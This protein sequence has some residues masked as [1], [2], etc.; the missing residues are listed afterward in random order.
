MELSVTTD[1]TF[2]TPNRRLAAYHLKQYQQQQLA[3]GKKS[4]E[5]MDILPISSW[6]ERLWSTWSYQEI[7]SKNNLLNANQELI[8]WEKIISEAK[9]SQH[10]LQ[11]SA[12]AEIAKSA[13][14]L[15]KQWE[16]D[17]H[18]P[19]LSL[20]EDSQTF[21]SWAQTFQNQCN[22]NHWVDHIRTGKI[23]AAK[24][25][26]LIGFT[27]L[28]PQQQ[29]LLSVCEQAGSE[30]Q[31]YH[32]SSK[33][34]STKRISLADKETEVRV[35]AQWAKSILEKKQSDTVRIACII[36]NL[37]DI[38]DTVNRIFT[39]VFTEK[40]YFRT[41]SLELAFNISAGKSLASYPVIHT[42]LQLLELHKNNIAIDKFSSILRSPFIGDAEKEMLKRAN[43]DIQL[44]RENIS[45]LSH[46][47]IIKNKFIPE[48]LLERFKNFVSAL[49]K[50]RAK[51]SISTWV[52]FFMELLTI[53]GWPGERNVNSEEYQTIQCWVDLLSEYASYDYVLKDCN[54]D[55]ALHYL[56]HIT[57]NTVFQIQSPETPVQIL[58]VLEAAEMRFDTMWCM[59]MDDTSWPPT[60][61]PNPFIPQQLQKILSM[62]HATAERE[63]NYCNKLLEQLKNSANEIIFSHAL[64]E[65]E[66]EVRVSSLIEKVSETTIE[67]LI[68]S[69]YTQSTQ[70]IFQHKH[71]ESI[72]DNMA[73][74]VTTE[75]IFGGTK[76]FE[77]QAACPFKAFAEL[78]LFA[79]P[80][81]ATS[82]GLRALDRGNIIH[83]AL[84][85]I[86]TDLKNS[87][88]LQSKSSDELQTLILKS[89]EAAI[90]Q[91][92]G[93]EVEQL[94]YLQLESTRLQKI[95]WDWMIIEKSRPAFDVI[96]QEQK[97]EISVANIKI[98]LRVDRI[99]QLENG[100]KI[101]IDY[102]TGKNNHIQNWF[103]HRPDAPQL[104]LYCIIDPE[105]TVSIAFAIIHPEYMELTGISK[106]RMTIETI[107]TLDAIKYEN[108]LFW[109]EQLT[110]WRETLEKLGQDFCAGHAKV[111]PKHFP[112][113]CEHCN[114]KSLC[115]IYEKTNMS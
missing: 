74:P 91:I 13:W 37:E 108:A 106:D 59:G 40:G 90:Y 27:E 16:I 97:Y 51:Q 99:D 66:T 22:K 15:L 83:K 86:W 8:L 115:R 34:C 52:N 39:D 71:L 31:H 18:H 11:K 100:E 20:T 32:Q 26:I 29:T 103:G 45:L 69:D 114:L 102:K 85:L 58:G 88:T 44:R 111:D 6:L 78:R 28:S 96:A 56:K 35:M 12:T 109:N 17:L 1:T 84:E 63:L 36:P 30:I 41:D 33:I 42:A 80:I 72:Q 2:L 48:L 54:F 77:L 110:L 60:P 4:W 7:K 73:P 79:K 5:S 104:P 92:T 9:E 64:F 55:S 75:L 98:N 43:C 76:I 38:R 81:E 94:Q 67:N 57:A 47:K 113:T 65:Q 89:I 3:D 10:L 21:L 93:D 112:Q 19:S 105:K 23:I 95:L 61:K 107:K 50:P 70:I 53:M 46:K 49:N 25:I 68:L 82:L 14:G 101:I 62:P 24:K 87:R